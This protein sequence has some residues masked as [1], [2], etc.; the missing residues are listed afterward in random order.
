MEPSRAHPSITVTG[1]KPPK[2]AR[3]LRAR[4]LLT[5]MMSEAAPVPSSYRP[6]ETV[7][8]DG[9]EPKYQITYDHGGNP[10]KKLLPTRQPH[11]FPVKNLQETIAKIS[12]HSNKRPRGFKEDNG[13]ENFLREQRMRTRP[14]DSAPVGSSRQPRAPPAPSQRGN[15]Q[16]PAWSCHPETRYFLNVY[17]KKELDHRIELS[18]KTHYIIGRMSDCDIQ[19]MDNSVSRYH[20]VLQHGK[21]GIFIYDCGSTHGSFVNDHKPLVNEGLLEKRKYKR[22]L[23]TD[24]IM[25]G[26]YSF[27]YIIEGGDTRQV[28]EAKKLVETTQQ[29][30]TH[31]QI[32]HQ[33]QEPR[34]FT[35]GNNEDND[36]RE[37]DYNID[38]RNPDRRDP[39]FK[40]ERLDIKAA[41][42][43]FRAR[44]FNEL[45][46]KN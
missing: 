29:P 5:K 19:I 14:R 13:A 24:I 9:S 25:F 6:D 34:S 21:D 39:Y 45:G 37:R 38:A 30:P 4:M 31:P 23:A 42:D 44:Y 18:K 11:G 28:F 15:Y 26:N 35:E 41:R 43:H 3:A 12:A 27:Y 8:E 32:Q 46:G 40:E 20:A 10:T 16:P 17:R 36:R 2:D 22:V 7:T 1:P 33:Q